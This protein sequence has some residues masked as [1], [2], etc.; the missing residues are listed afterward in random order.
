MCLV[1]CANLESHENSCSH[2]SVLTFCRKES[3][4]KLILNDI[5]CE[6][7]AKEMNLTKLNYIQPK[8]IKNKITP[9]SVT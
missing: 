2:T 9:Y 3:I 5:R 7:E 1:M 6:K 8:L 4:T